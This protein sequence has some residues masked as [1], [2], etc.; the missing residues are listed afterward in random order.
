MSYI[1]LKDELTLSDMKNFRNMAE[2][3]LI[4]RAV[5]LG[6]AGSANELTIRPFDPLLDAGAA[7][8]QWRTAALAVIGTE[9]SCFQAVPAPI[10]ANNK[11]A[12]FYKIGCEE[13]PM[14]VARLRIRTAAAGNLMAEFDLEQFVNAW[15]QE[16]YF[17]QPVPI[18]PT[19]T[20]AINVTARIATGLFARVQLGGLVAEPTGQTIA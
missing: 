16:G 2:E 4:A 11:C 9:Y 1:V 13:V 12:V 17:S 15:T 19:M 5:K 18:D 10:L 7:L 20:F 14:P 6:V 3:A 8:A